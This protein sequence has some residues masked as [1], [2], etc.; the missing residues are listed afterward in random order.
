MYNDR[1]LFLKGFLTIDEWAWKSVP[2]AIISF[3]ISNLSFVRLYL[4]TPRGSYVDNR[5]LIVVYNATFFIIF[6]FFFT[7]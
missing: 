7:T 6:F 1:V 4:A 3:Q 2:T 5:K